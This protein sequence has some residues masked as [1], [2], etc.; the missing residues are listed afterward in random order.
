MNSKTKY[1][2]SLLALTL[3]APVGM[4]SAFAHAPRQDDSVHE[5]SQT[6]PIY[7]PVMIQYMKELTADPGKTVAE[8]PIANQT[9]SV[10]TIVREITDD[11]YAVKPTT[12]IDGEKISSEKFRITAI[13]NSTYKLVNNGLGIRQVFTDIPSEA[14]GAGSGSST[15]SSARIDLYDREHG[16]PPTL[17]LHDI[18]SGCATL[19][20]ALFQ[21][22]IRP[23]TV[24]VTWEASPFYMHWCFIP[25]EFQQGEVRHVTETVFLN[26]HGDRRG[27]HAFDNPHGGT[28]W[29]SV[30]MDFEYGVW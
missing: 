17:T 27:N 12:R 10:T 30:E 6:E 26:G 7:D 18:Y 20:H 1:T 25:H 29:Y 14:A 21:A 2:T 11:K 28:I 22:P 13:D 24:D 23:D 19:N 16:T 5:P 4:N 3:L 15:P 9:Y 8:R